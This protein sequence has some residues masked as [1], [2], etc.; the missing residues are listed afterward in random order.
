MEVAYYLIL[1]VNKIDLE[2]AN[3]EKVK[4]EL[5]QHNIVVEQMGGD[6]P[7]VEISALKRKNLDELIE[8][9]ELQ[10]E[11]LE[12]KA[13]MTQRAEGVVAKEQEDA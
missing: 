9:I 10:A 12:L 4:Q 6:I 1:A 11:I 3:P 2:G 8:N 7:V 5:L 13:S